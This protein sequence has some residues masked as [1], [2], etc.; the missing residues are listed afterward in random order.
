MSSG[1]QDRANRL[2]RPNEPLRH[3][4]CGADRHRPRLRQ[5]ARRFGVTAASGVTAT[6]VGPGES[7]CSPTL[8]PSPLMSLGVHYRGSGLVD[9]SSTNRLP[10][11]PG[12]FHPDRSS[13]GL[14]EQP[15]EV[16][17]IANALGGV[18]ADRARRLVRW[19]CLSFEP[20]TVVG[21]AFEDA[22]RNRHRQRAT[23]Y[24]RASRTRSASPRSWIV[25]F[26]EEGAD[27]GHDHTGFTERGR[28]RGFQA[29]MSSTT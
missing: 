11:D 13:A 7:L 21:L 3:R 5:T 16:F 9:P 25:G 8:P 27:M 23:R 10:D 22:A 20:T 1:G 4:G 15:A 28:Q 29:V 12:A 26:A 14:I 6:V 24:A 19:G 2:G 18:G 17:R